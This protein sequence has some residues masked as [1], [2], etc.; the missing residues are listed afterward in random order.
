[1][2]GAI[3]IDVLVVPRASRSRVAGLQDGRLRLQLA[4]APV[5]GEANAALVELVADLLGVR[6]SAVR[7]VCGAT[8]RRK[9]LRIE[10]ADPARLPR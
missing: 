8:G 9:R 6:R 4:A 5:E 10:G 1:V 2:P 3:E 7:L